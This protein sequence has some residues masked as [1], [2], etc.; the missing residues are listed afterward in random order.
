M[1]G[2][3]QIINGTIKDIQMYTCCFNPKKRA[4][5]EA[6][7][8]HPFTISVAGSTPENEGLHLEVRQLFIAKYNAV[9]RYYLICNI[10]HFD[11]SRNGLQVCLT[12]IHLQVSPA[13]IELLSRSYMTFS[14]T[15]VDK[16]DVKEVT[17]D[18]S[19]L[20]EVAS[21]ED[22]DYW[23]LKTGEGGRDNVTFS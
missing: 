10:V 4:S 19:N 18:Y 16:T 11:I 23:F 22:D 21:Y 12:N 5:T 9:H 3:R 2:K 17:E 8:L 1:I 15:A 13:T 7:F 20:W 14:G 6:K